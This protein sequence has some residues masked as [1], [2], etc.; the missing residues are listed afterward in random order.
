MSLCTPS[1]WIHHSVWDGQWPLVI[2][3]ISSQLCKRHDCQKPS[4][5]SQQSI[6]SHNGSIS[7]L[8][9]N[10]TSLWIDD[11]YYAPATVSVLVLAINWY[12]RVATS[13]KV[14]NSKPS[15]HPHHLGCES[16]FRRGSYLSVD[17]FLLQ[18]FIWSRCH[19]LHSCTAR[20][21]MSS[22]I[23]KNLRGWLQNLWG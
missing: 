5:L 22:R 11:Q 3:S 9:R 6:N 21:T 7:L 10:L 1:N 20:V 12:S 17:F 15:H 23:G 8:K 13:I 14:F 16:L 18:P 2:L 4:K 19:K